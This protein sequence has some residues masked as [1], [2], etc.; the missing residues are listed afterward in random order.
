MGVD[1][2]LFFQLRHVIVG[3]PALIWKEVKAYEMSGSD[4][5]GQFTDRAP[6]Q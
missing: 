2:N 1:S 6:A 5:S 3:K 4:H